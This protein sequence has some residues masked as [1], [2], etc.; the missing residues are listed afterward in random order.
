MIRSIRSKAIAFAGMAVAALGLSQAAHARTDVFLNIGIPVAPVYSQPAPVY[1]E[2]RPVYVQP[3]P[4]YVQPRPVYVQPRP[5]VYGA[6]VVVYERNDW[7]ERKWH[8]HHD[9]RGDGR[10]YGY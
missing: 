7:R 3:R 4:V 5:V 6:P 10:R 9:H 2:P 1:V 8:R